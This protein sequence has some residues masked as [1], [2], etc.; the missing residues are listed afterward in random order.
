MYPKPLD[1]DVRVFRGVSSTYEEEDVQSIFEHGYRGFATGQFQKVLGYY[2]KALWNETPNAR[3]EMGGTYTSVVS[4][5]GAHFAIGSGTTLSKEESIL[6]EFVLPKGSPEICGPYKNEF[7]L[8]PSYIHGS[9]II[10][11]YKL[12]TSV[13]DKTK[14]LDVI[15]NGAVSPKYAL[16]DFVENTLNINQTEVE[17]YNT[18]SCSEKP[19][20][21]VDRPT[22]SMYSDAEDFYARYTEADFAK[23][24]EKLW[25]FYFSGRTTYE[26]DFFAKSCDPELYCC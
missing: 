17:K 6:L 19:V 21:T 13:P 16:G 1:E 14:V 2:A 23:D 9:N 11:I 26:D 24:Q 5:C 7:E 15:P 4:E 18:L 10:A 20:V 12:D 22:Y 3:W 25:E 8:V